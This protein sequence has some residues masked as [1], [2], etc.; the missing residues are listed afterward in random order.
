V[1]AVSKIMLVS[2]DLHH[3]KYHESYA[4]LVME[5]CALFPYARMPCNANKACLDVH[6]TCPFAD[7]LTCFDCSSCSTFASRLATASGALFGAP[8]VSA[9][10]GLNGDDSR[11][12]VFDLLGRNGTG[13]EGLDERNCITIVSMITSLLRSE[14]CT[15]R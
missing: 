8:F 10:S 12:C 2:I 5:T 3:Y 6:A 11:F 7:P 1:A 9:F 15:Y 4:A 14:V 13:V